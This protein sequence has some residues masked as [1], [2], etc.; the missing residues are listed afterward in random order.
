[1]LIVL[2]PSEGKTAP[3]AGPPVELGSLAYADELTA[4][5]ERVL[6]ALVRTSSGKQRG[7]A[8]KA[9]GLSAGQAGELERNAGLGSAPAGPAGEVYTGVLYERL[10]LPALPAE[11]RAR[12]L[13]SSALWGV[14]APDD[15]I[16][17]YRLSIAARLPR[18]PGLATYWRPALERALPGDGLVVDLR[19]GG[20]AAAWTPR[21][22]TL[23]TVRGFTEQD[24]RRKVVSH[25]VKAI[26]GDV[27]GALLRAPEPPE[28]PEDVA[29]IAAAAGHEVELTQ[30]PAGASVDVISKA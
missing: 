30:T 6:A 24:G 27:A 28:T 25:F 16:P 10:R 23:V 17:A 21:D 9:L 13:I 8:L 3:A 1:V 29:A 7:R 12:V 22:A 26:R 18:I 14:V 5:R 20:Y 11:A 19:S 15:R 2:P 4:E